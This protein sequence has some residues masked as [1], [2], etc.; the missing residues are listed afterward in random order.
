M[1]AITADIV[2]APIAVPK[3]PGFWSGVL[4][5]L[6]RDPVALAALAVLIVIVAIAILAPYIAPYDPTKGSVI[7][8]LKPIGT[9]GYF[10]G[11]DE[12]GRD[13]L[14]RLIYGARLSLIMA[15]YLYRSPSSSARS[16]AS[17]PV[18]P[19]ASPIR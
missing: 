16:S 15:S 19:V 3:S 17:S 12:L 6:C 13:M 11:T 10:L 7:R 14:S 5:R 4:H 2:P 9:E 1:A 8:R 18:M